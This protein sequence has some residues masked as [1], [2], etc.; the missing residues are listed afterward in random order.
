[1]VFVTNGYN[2][3]SE[4]G[5]EI[6]S[7]VRATHIRQNSFKTFELFDW[8]NGQTKKKALNRGLLTGIDAFDSGFRRKFA[9]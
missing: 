9:L 6:E 7:N 4:I 2:N 8:T 1:M 3:L 5:T